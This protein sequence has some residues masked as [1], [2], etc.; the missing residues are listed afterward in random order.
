MTKDGEMFRLLAAVNILLLAVNVLG[1][2]YV[3]SQNKFMSPVPVV[4]F[5]LPGGT[6][7]IAIYVIYMSV[8]VISIVK[9]MSHHQ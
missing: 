2:G 8:T 3:I 7:L 5:F 9:L 1:L 4:G 6:L